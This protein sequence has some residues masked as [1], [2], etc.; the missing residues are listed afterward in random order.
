MSKVCFSLK[1]LPFSS[2]ILIQ[3]L[4]T[5]IDISKNGFIF[6]RDVVEI[7]RYIKKEGNCDQVTMYILLV[8]VN[9]RKMF[10]L[11]D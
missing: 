7:L 5:A 11:L 9:K 6:L 8:K 4:F 10:F 3:E 2:T 1:G